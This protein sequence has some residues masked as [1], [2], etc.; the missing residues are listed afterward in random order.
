MARSDEVKP[1]INVQPPSLV[2][3]VQQNSVV[4]AAYLQWIAQIPP[5]LDVQTLT[6]WF[7]AHPRPPMIDEVKLLELENLRDE[8]TLALAE[9]NKKITY[10]HAA[11][12]TSINN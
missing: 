11:I 2:D 3:A 1:Y 4:S 7:K 9:I 8:I 10:A 5:K 6:L 12:R